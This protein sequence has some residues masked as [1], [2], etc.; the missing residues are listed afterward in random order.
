MAGHLKTIQSPINSGCFG[1]IQY[2]KVPS[3]WSTILNPSQL[4]HGHGLAS[5]SEKEASHDGWVRC[6][7]ASAMSPEFLKPF[8]MS[9]LEPVDKIPD[10]NASC[11]AF[12]NYAVRALQMMICEPNMFNH[13]LMWDSKF[14]SWRLAF[15]FLPAFRWTPP[16]FF[17]CY[18]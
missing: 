18:M 14:Q 8:G 17:K 7:D 3:F 13:Q 5:V 4:Q 2:V 6:T 11:V 1:E 9:L 10:G 12:M 15:G 16:T